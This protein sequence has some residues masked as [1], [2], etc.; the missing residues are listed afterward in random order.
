MLEGSGNVLQT[1]WHPEEF[2]KP[3]RS[4]DCGFGDVF[5][6]HQNL[7]VDSDEINL[8]EYS[9]VS[10]VGGGILYVGYWQELWHH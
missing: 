2:K 8:G 9:A 1:E 7:V 6:S 10:V 3:K 5:S 4:N